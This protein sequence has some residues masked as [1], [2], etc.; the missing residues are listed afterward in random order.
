M[1]LTPAVLR[2]IKPEVLKQALEQRERFAKLEKLSA[3]RW[4]LLS[5]VRSIETEMEILN[6]QVMQ[7]SSPTANGKRGR[8]KGY[9]LSAATRAK[10]R[11]AALR[12]Y[13]KKDEPAKPARKWKMSA[14]GRQRIAD[15]ARRRWAAVKAAKEGQKEKAATS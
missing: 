13:G 1:R 8:R 9:K 11:A 15:A 2:R 5:E 3:R 10:M 6:R 7:K 4:T 12:R 14:E